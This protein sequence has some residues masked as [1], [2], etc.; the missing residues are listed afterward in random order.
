MKEKVPIIF[1]FFSNLN[2]NMKIDGAGKKTETKVS[3]FHQR[4]PLNT[5]LPLE[6]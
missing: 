6:G 1:L 3:A 2:T 5:F 4:R